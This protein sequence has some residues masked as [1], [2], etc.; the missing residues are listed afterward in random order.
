MGMFFAC[1]CIA[2]L[3]GAAIGYFLNIYVVA[4]LAALV[5]Y[6]YFKEYGRPNPQ[7]GTSGQM[8]ALIVGFLLFAP[9]TATMLVVSAVVNWEK[10]ETLLWKLMRIFA[11]VFLR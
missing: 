4:V 9:A 5:T 11:L 6:L 1:V 8:G 2:L 3:I 7:P 10:L